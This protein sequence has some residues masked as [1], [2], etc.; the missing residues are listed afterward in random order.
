MHHDTH[1]LPCKTRL[2]YCALL[3]QLELNL[4]KQAGVQEVDRVEQHSESHG[5]G[6][7]D[8][9]TSTTAILGALPHRSLN[10]EGEE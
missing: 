5:P 6:Q 10:G 4:R 2:K 8:G 3:Q 7:C 9:P 1:Q